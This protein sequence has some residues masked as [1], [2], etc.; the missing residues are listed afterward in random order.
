VF[1]LWISFCICRWRSA[2][3][4]ALAAPSSGGEAPHAHA[5]EDTMADIGIAPAGD[6]AIIE[7]TGFRLSWG[8]IFAGLFVATAL[9]LTLALLGVAIGL[10][11]WDPAVPGGVRAGQVATGVG[12][13]TVVSGLIALFIGGMTTGRLA[14]VLTRKDGALH[15]V[16]VWSLTMVLITWLIISGATMLLG[17]AFGI[18][19]QTAGAAIGAVGQ[20]VPTDVAG[21]A[22]TGAVRGEERQVLV[23]EIAQRS[24]LTQAEAEQLVTDAEARAERTRQ[25]AGAQLETAR[26]QAPGVAQDVADTTAQGAWWALLAMGLSVGATAWG[27]AIT[28]RE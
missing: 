1:K 5:K 13:W 20:V 18:I 2:P 10:S 8:A 3:I 28:A 21:P 24:G 14:G 16:V 26:Q 17:G 23:A 11:A 12:I 27:A 7:H 4:S 22:L 6:A 9:H 15:G 19:G 25:Q